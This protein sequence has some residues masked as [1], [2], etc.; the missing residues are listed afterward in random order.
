MR[1]IFCLKIKM[2]IKKQYV[3]KT[4]NWNIRNSFINC[5]NSEIQMT[6]LI[7]GKTFIG[8]KPLI[9][10]AEIENMIANKRAQIVPLLT[11]NRYCCNLFMGIY[12]QPF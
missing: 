1:K 4:K 9:N 12:K 10:A 7:Y 8:T 6:F 5:N 11:S 3:N 2:K